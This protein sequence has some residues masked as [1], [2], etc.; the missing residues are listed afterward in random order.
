M[1]TILVVSTSY[2]RATRVSHRW[3][4]NFVGKLNKLG[5]NTA[6][7]FGSKVDVVS[8]RTQIRSADVLVFFGHGEP[9]RFIGQRGW[10]SIGAGPTLIDVTTVTVI[11]HVKVYA[12]CCQASLLLGRAY[13]AI[14]PQG[15]FLG[16]AAPFGASYPN[17]KY[18]EETVTAGGLDFISGTK[19]PQVVQVD[20]REAWK[21]LSDQFF[22]GALSH[23]P[24]AFPAG[25]AAAANSTFVTISP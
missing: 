4:N 11:G 10:L 18:F 17:A 14:A 21:D 3:A 22:N 19:S 20:L 7:L 13:S 15:A 1:G 9:D 12:V 23:R 25:F 6:K 2:D 5:F 16:Y 8:L 24:D